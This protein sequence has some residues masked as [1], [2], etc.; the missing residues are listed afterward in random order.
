MILFR[1]IIISVPTY[2]IFVYWTMLGTRFCISDILMKLILKVTCSVTLL[3]GFIFWST[4][5][6]E[7]LRLVT[8]LYSG[9]SVTL[10]MILFVDNLSFSLWGIFYY[11]WFMW[12]YFC[13]MFSQILLI[14]IR[15]CS[16]SSLYSTSTIMVLYTSVILVSMCCYH[17]YV[18]NIEIRFI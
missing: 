5:V 14:V 18:I 11:R 12:S 9:N 1:F 6:P 4:I 8:I 15:E 7:V 10:V 17:L 13:I 2:L 16:S 3:K